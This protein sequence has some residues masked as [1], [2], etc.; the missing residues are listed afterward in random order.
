MNYDDIA[1]LLGIN[2]SHTTKS[3]R[4]EYWRLKT[5]A[6]VLPSP[7]SKESP[8][9]YEFGTKEEVEAFVSGYSLVVRYLLQVEHTPQ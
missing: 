5:P 9:I 7:F 2:I 3:E 1:C 8:S 6:S 4:G